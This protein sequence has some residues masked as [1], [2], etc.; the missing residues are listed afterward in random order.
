MTH[1][2][3]S[4]QT[5]SRM[6]NGIDSPP[7]TET[8][9]SP[10]LRGPAGREPWGQRE[11][12]WPL[13][14]GSVVLLVVSIPSLY[15]WHRYQLDRVSN[16]LLQHANELEQAGNDEQA[17]HYLYRCLQLTDKQPDVQRDL[18][19]RLARSYDRS[20]VLS[21]DKSTVIQWYYRAVGAAPDDLALQTRLAELFLETR[22]FVPAEEQAG[23]VLKKSLSSLK[24]S[25]FWPWRDTDNYAGAD[26]YWC[27]RYYVNCRTFSGGSRPMWR[28]PRPWRMC[29]E[30]RLPPTNSLIP[31]PA[32]MRLWTR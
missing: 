2:L 15:V 21:A 10:N 17:V 26:R 4:Q 9:S 22:Q 30:K 31:L 20:S 1:S 11:L 8:P 19:I 28:L 13:L 18:L 27:S 24:P 5:A 32:P 29:I 6:H 12:N 7:V 14:I 16:A 23:A 3:H 25:G